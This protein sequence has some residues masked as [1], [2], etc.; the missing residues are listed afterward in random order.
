MLTVAQAVWSLAPPQLCVAMCQPD[1]KEC[2]PVS[3]LLFGG[4]AQVG[5][6]LPN[7]CKTLSWSPSTSLKKSQSVPRCWYTIPDPCNLKGR[8]ILAHSL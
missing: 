4:L 7:K 2:V 1:R 3:S 8:F 6:C 5:A